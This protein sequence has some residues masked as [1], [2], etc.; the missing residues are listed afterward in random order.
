MHDAE[1]RAGSRPRVFVSSVIEGFA[2]FRQATREAIAA[3]GGE[4][5]LVNED[6]PSLALRAASYTLT[7]NI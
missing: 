4:P 1:A 5:V 2:E 7:C 6:S 3:A